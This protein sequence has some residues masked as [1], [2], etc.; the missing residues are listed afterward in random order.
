MHL[1]AELLAGKEK[2]DEQR[3]TS[4]LRRGLA[5]EFGTVLLGQFA[6]GL[7]GERAVGDPAVFAGQPDLADRLAFHRTAEIG[8]QIARPPH[9]LVKLRKQPEMDTVPA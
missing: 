1:H 5:G 6:Q 8:T 3:K 2:L 9:P 7:P 4:G